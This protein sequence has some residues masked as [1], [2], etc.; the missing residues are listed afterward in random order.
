MGLEKFSVVDPCRP[1]QLFDDAQR[2][3]PSAFDPAGYRIDL[4][5][6]S[7]FH[8]RPKMAL[9]FDIP[10]IFYGENEAEYGNPITDGDTALRDWAYSAAAKHT[11]IFLGGGS[12]ADLTSQFG[13]D[14]SDLQPYLPAVPDRVAEKNI[15]VHYLGYYFK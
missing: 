3:G 8:D 2:P 9:L 7:G 1:L 10:L 14:P 15:E 12:T 4:S 11:K 5:P 13:V 6:V